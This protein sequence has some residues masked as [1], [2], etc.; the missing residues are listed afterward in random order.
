MAVG[1]SGIV[2]PQQE[3]GQWQIPEEEGANA[4]AR[5]C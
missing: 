4:K 2:D 5:R 3:D 1:A